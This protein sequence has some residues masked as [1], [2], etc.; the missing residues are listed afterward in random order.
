MPFHDRSRWAWRSLPALAAVAALASTSP[1]HA[2]SDGLTTSSVTFTGSGGVVLHGAV[3]APAAGGDRPG[4][5][6][7]SGSGP[8]KGADELAQAEAFARDGVVSL[9]YDKR[10]AGYSQFQRSYPVLAEDALDA[11]RL[12]RG[13]RG[14]VPARVGLWGESEGAWVVSLAASRSPD[15]AFLVTVGAAGMT[16]AR[17][18]A[19]SD[20][21]VLRHAGVS[22]SLVPAVQQ[23]AI[24]QAAGAGLFPEADYDP[25]PAWEHVHQPVLALWGDDDEE[26]PIAESAR[27]IQGALERGGDTR[28]TIRFF[29]GASHGLRVADGGGFEGGSLLRAPRVTALAP[30]YPELVTTWVA[31][32]DARVAGAAAL[33]A[34]RQASAADPRTLPLAPLRWYESPSAQ[35]GALALFLLAFGVFPLAGRRVWGRLPRPV[36]QPARILA[37]TGLVAAVGTPAYLLLLLLTAGGIAG[38]VVEGRPLPWLVLQLLSVAAGVATA[39]VAVAWRLKRHDVPRRH[40]ARLALLVSGGAVLVPWAWYWGLLRP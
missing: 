32:P 40:V 15:V 11:L 25:V 19:W 18:T 26:V 5:V 12:L 9:V 30:G 4:V 31:D 13:W 3:V 37:W 36:R 21:N 27:D 10:T 1:V 17:Q 39:A 16:P 14:V 7:V 29:P 35:A 28:V 33:P 8:Q 22:G 2:A 38:P 34:P 24:R 23:T 20:A 6:L